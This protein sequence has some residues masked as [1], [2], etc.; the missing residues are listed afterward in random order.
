M[1]KSTR[2]R[3]LQLSG[4]GSVFGLTGCLRLTG[5]SGDDS[6]GSTSTTAGS[7]DSE[8]STSTTEGS[9]YQ[10]TVVEG[11]ISSGADVSLKGHQIEIY[12]TSNNEFYDLPIDDGGFAQTVEPDSLLN[13]T[14]FYQQDAEATDV[15]SVP[16]LYSLAEKISVS[17]EKEK[18]G[19]LTLPQAYKTE[20]QIVDPDGNPVENFPIGFRCPN[21]SGTTARPFTTTED[22]YAKYKDA[23]ETGFYFADTVTLEGGDHES[24]SRLRDINVTEQSEYT[25]EVLPDRYDL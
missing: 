24:R 12:N 5:G 20:I 14:F 6:G 13:L 9:S 25:I 23:S 16:M 4:F 11:S 15:D 2:R 17:G 1:D 7:S 19:T 3:F 8:G 21:G 18:L 22:G 10:Y